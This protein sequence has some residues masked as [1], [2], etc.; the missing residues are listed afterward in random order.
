MEGEDKELPKRLF[1]SFRKENCSL[2]IYKYKDTSKWEQDREYVLNNHDLLIL[3]WELVG[4]PPFQG[5]LEILWE[6]VNLQSLP[7]ILIYTQENDTSIIELNIRSFF[8]TPYANI[9]ERKSK[10]EEFC[11]KL[12]EE[13]DISDSNQLFKS[14]YTECKQL[15]LNYDRE[16]IKESLVHIRNYCE[17]EE[18]NFNSFMNKMM[19]LSKSVL[20]ISKIE[21]LLEFIVFQ[22]SNAVVN[23]KGYSMQVFPI[24]GAE[25][26]FVIN[27][28]T[29]T[30][31]VKP[32]ASNPESEIVISPERVYKYFAESI[33]KP[34]RNFLALLSLEMKTLYRENAGM[35]GNELYNI[36]EMAFFHHQ[37]N[38]N[39]EDDFYDFLRNCWKDQLSAFNFLQN[40]KLF[41]VLGEYK[42]KIG[43]ETEIEKY[44]H[45]NFKKFQEELVKLNY[46][47]SF[48][49]LKRK[50]NDRIHFGDLFLLSKDKDGNEQNGFMLCITPH[51]DCLHTENINNKFYFVYADNV[52]LEEGL[53]S[54]EQGFYSFLIYKDKPLC[55]KWSKKP[56]TL[57][58][59]EA[60]ANIS[61]PIQVRY[62][63]S[64][65][66][67]IYK[68]TQKENYTQRIANEAFSHASRIGIELAGIKQKTTTK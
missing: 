18:L 27:S 32:K 43:Y 35:I 44:K 56:F 49:N 41:S 6:A 33:Y 55:I 11:A 47:Y 67:L 59:P 29:I 8:G 57:Y 22:F 10:Y 45:D 21:N 50:E 30:I 28:T 19:N 48:L 46:Q 64:D 20:N 37:K 36:D 31:F 60:K 53:K 7:F 15:I 25:H 1:E 38:L 12:E 2:D 14:I 61:Q 52:P 65:Y 9:T 63:D 40:P 4:D 17:K 58:I 26:S 54:A 62:H 42:S 16:I 23:N 5:S 51:C 39:S 34:P 3:D 66:Y 24:D 13:T 68:A